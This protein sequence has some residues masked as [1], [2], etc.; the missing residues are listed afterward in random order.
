MIKK[1]LS[2]I[3]KSDLRHLLSAPRRFVRRRG[4]GIHSPF[5]FDFVRRV[6]AQPCSFY[7]YPQL[8]AEARKVGIKRR[9]VRLVFRVALFFRPSQVTYLGVCNSAIKVAVDVACPHPNKCSGPRLAI[10]SGVL[11][12]DEIGEALR[13]AVDGGVVIFLGVKT[14]AV[15]M[16]SVWSE[17]ECGMLFLGT[18][19]AIYTGLQHLPRQS[20]NVWI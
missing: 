3:T 15:A 11:T 13:C 19:T 9:V 17:A 1:A 10:V 12:E 4:F 16:H 14:E 8:D 7:C 2:K 5:A 18:D 6:I 20:F